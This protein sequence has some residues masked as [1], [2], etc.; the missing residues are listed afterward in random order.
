[1]NATGCSDKTVAEGNPEEPSQAEHSQTE[2]RPVLMSGGILFEFLPNSTQSDPIKPY[3]AV[4]Q[5]LG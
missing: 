4:C 3:S 5:V 1:M 2:L